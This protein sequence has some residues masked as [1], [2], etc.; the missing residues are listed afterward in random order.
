MRRSARLRVV[1][2]PVAG[3]VWILV[4]EAIREIDP[5]IASVGCKPVSDE[6]RSG[7]QDVTALLKR[8]GKTSQNEGS[9]R[10]SG[11]IRSARKRIRAV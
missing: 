4:L 6:R 8:Q 11:R 10:S 5:V 3:V 7:K 9:K 2:D 1:G